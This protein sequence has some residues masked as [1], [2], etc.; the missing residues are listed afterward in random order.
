MLLNLIRRA[1][2]SV[3]EGW[4]NKDRRAPVLFTASSL[5]MSAAGMLAGI[6]VVH[7]IAPHDMGLWSSVNLAMTYSVFV[8]A[9]V[10]NGLSRELPYYLGAENKEMATHLAATTL[11]YT[12][13]GCVLALLGG[14]GTVLFLVWKHADVKLIYSVAAITLVLIF[15]F[16]SGFLFVTFRSK[17][18]FLALSRVQMWQTFIIFL[19]LP[20]IFLGYGGMVLR[21]VALAGFALYLMHRMRPMPVLP[22]WSKD[23]FVLLLKT[24]IPIFATDY[25]AS[26]AAT[27]DKVALLRFGGLEQVGLYTLAL[28][29]FSA[30]QV[31]PISIAHY[32]YPRMSHHFGRTNNPRILWGMAWKSSIIVAGCMLPLAIAGSFILPIAVKF[33]FPKYITGIQAAEI[34]LFTGV[35]YGATL[36]TNALLSMKAWSHLIAYQLSSSAMMAVGPFLGIRLFSSPLSGVAYGMLGANVLTA[37]LGLVI[38]FVATHREPLPPVVADQFVAGPVD[39][40]EI[41]SSVGSL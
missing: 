18:S 17:S 35:A 14:A 28:T 30:F 16:Y 9:G 23:S 13:G 26:C 29:A 21:V 8:L 6:V 25:I 19:S 24:G 5:A 37:V 31:V 7:Y 33:L 3:R 11:F 39:E 34:A 2:S 15:K 38:T 36:G 4:S 1:S 22:S 41:Q 12:V 40:E 32:V 20:L 27:F 10:Q